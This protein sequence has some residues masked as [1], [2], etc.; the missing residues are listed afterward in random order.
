MA[1]RASRQVIIVEDDQS[2][3]AVLTRLLRRHGFEAHAADSAAEAINLLHR[4]KLVAMLCDVRLPDGSGLDLV[5]EALRIDPHLGIVM[6]SGLGDAVT[7]KTAMERGA[8]DYLVK[9]VR[10]EDV[11][12]AVNRAVQHCEVRAIREEAERLVRE[13]VGMRTVELEQERMAA[14]RLAV[15]VVET[16]AIAMEAKDVFLRGHS[17]RVAELGASIARAVG[18][19]EDMVEAVR[20]AGRL[21]DIGK[22]GIRES[23]LNKPGPLTPEEYAHVKTH[24]E[25]GVSMLTPLTHLGVS[26]DFIRH[27]HERYDG[28]GYPAALKGD[29]ISLGGRI[30]LAADI[31]DALTSTR[32]YRASLTPAETLEYLRAESGRLIDPDV[33]QA[34][35]GTIRGSRSPTFLDVRMPP[36]EP[37]ARVATGPRG[38]VPPPAR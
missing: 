1:G 28:S 31:Y 2:Q 26:L 36:N 16:L 32:P 4:L 12:G 15:S 30:L 7:A 10:N 3:V 8:V 9:P 11:V 35:D 21:H 33:F 37:G 14:R 24:V 23:V 17:L 5:T 6:L 20:L 22:I 18:C 34:L 13:Q 27:H 29:R 19:D 38:I 25:I